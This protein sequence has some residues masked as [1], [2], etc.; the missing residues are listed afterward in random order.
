MQ[1][2]KENERA[3]TQ[4]KGL[5]AEITIVPGA[6]TVHLGAGRNPNPDK[7][8]GIGIRRRLRPWRDH[9]GN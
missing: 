6:D 2:G 1:L 4:V 3:A 8:E 9:K 7:G 5:S